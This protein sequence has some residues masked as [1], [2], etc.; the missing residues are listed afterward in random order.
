MYW[1]KEKVMA[2][3]GW[4]ERLG[5]DYSARILIHRWVFISVVTVLLVPPLASGTIVLFRFWEQMTFGMAVLLGTV[6][7]GVILL[8]AK[9]LRDYT[10]LQRLG[11]PS[12][13]SS[14]L[15]EAVSSLMRTLILVYFI[16]GT[17]FLLIGKLLR[18]R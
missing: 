11:E 5:Q 4:F 18:S 15:G 2:V 17:S 6:V 3:N 10:R 13:E 14:R 7:C 9:T 1:V 12:R 8:W 16:A